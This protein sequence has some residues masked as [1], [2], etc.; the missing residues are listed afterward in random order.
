MVCIYSSLALSVFFSLCSKRARDRRTVSIFIKCEK[1]RYGVRAQESQKQRCA[2]TGCPVIG[3][4]QV[5][6]VVI[7]SFP[8]LLVLSPD[9]FITDKFP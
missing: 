5:A 9:F 1:V 3:M 6:F 2:L 4:R 7:V 8:P